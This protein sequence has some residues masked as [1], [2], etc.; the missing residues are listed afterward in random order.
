M[1]FSTQHRIGN[2]IS[3]ENVGS[4]ST[5]TGL[6]SS[7]PITNITASAAPAAST[8]KDDGQQSLT[9]W[10]SDAF[11]KT[12]SSDFSKSAQQHQSGQPAVA[13]VKK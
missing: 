6:P 3:V 11:W 12:F 7:Q 10:A 5:P 8:A 2:Q 13:D 4:T 1:F 9:S